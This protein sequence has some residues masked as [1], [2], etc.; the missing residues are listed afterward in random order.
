[1][2][3]VGSEATWSDDVVRIQ[4]F[5]EKATFGLISVA[6]FA[7]GEYQIIL[8]GRGGFIRRQGADR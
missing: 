5:M 7:V 1:M 8:E 4:F 6:P 3:F 2:R